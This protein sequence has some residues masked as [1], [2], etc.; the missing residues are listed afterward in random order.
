MTLFALRIEKGSPDDYA[1]AQNRDLS[2]ECWLIKAGL[3]ALLL[4]LILAAPM[5]APSVLAASSE[6]MQ[7]HGR[8]PLKP[9]EIF[10]TAWTIFADG[11]ID[12][13]AGARLKRFIQDK[14]IPGKS[15]LVLN[16]PGGSVLG[17]IELGRVIRDYDLLTDVGRDSADTAEEM[18]AGECY[19]AC[20]L[21]FL[22]GDYR[23]IQQASKYG[24][25]RFY[26]T[27]KGDHDSDAAQILSASIV[28]YIRDMDVEPELFGEMIMAGNKQINIIPHD[29]LVRLNVINNGVKKTAWTIES[30][31]A[32]IYL[33]GERETYRGI[34]KFLLLCN[35]NGSVSLYAIFDP[36][37]RGNQI[38]EMKAIS[39]LIDG[40]Q[41]PIAEHRLFG[42]SLVN[43]WINVGFSLN[44]N[45]LGIF[46][47]AQTVG[48]AFQYSY[49]APSF[50]GFDDM[51]F[52]DG[53][54]K[55]P[56]FLRACH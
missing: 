1:G 41:I 45:L 53:A 22:G 48:V 6:K 9:I 26:F 23:Y 7:F 51:D 30:I 5:A 33:K 35:P 32:G 25:H 18:T 39:L 16:S 10:G 3:V 17:G 44:D 54:K 27:T 42:P 37:G 36:E 20:A 21:A 56:G 19:S 15:T 55:L 2:G 46:Q 47:R 40:E 4:S 49:S 13:D 28:Q 31:D 38:I 14:S 8:P 50:L 34:N 12:A 52:S 29:E 43:G 11:V 24:V